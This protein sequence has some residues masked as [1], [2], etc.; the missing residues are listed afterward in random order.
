MKS[1]GLLSLDQPLGGDLPALAANVE[2]DPFDDHEA[3]SFHVDYLA[4]SG[5]A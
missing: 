1:A 3:A 2:E 5:T 4:E